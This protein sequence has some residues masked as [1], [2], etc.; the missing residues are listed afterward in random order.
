MLLVKIA[1]YFQ[2]GIKG[3]FW[4]YA[5]TEEQALAK[6]RD[7]MYTYW[8]QTNPEPDLEIVEMRIHS[9]LCTS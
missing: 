5:D 8:G 4:T 2:E 1:Y 3:T 9:N 6:G 7:R